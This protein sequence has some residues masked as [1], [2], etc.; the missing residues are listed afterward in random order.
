VPEVAKPPVPEVAKPPVP[1]VAKPPVPEIA[2]PSAPEVTRPAPSEPVRTPAPEAPRSLAPQP[3]RPADIAPPKAES[4][5]RAPDTSSD[6]DPTKPGIDPDAI[7]RRA[8]ELARQGTGQRAPLA[9]P[10]PAIEK[11]KSKLEKAIEDARK[12]DCR[13]AYKSLGLAA[14][15]PLIANEFGDGTCRW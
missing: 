2:K 3:A 6:Y 15:V 13:E 7:R 11:P 1:E 10:L 9:F 8:S 4:P 12:P 5:F 14:V